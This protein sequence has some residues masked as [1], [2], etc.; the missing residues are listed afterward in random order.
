MDSAPTAGGPPASPG[1]LDGRAC[2]SLL[3]AADAG[4]LHTAWRKI[5]SYG[6]API[7][8]TTVAGLRAKWSPPSID[9]PHPSRPTL[10]GHAVMDL[11]APIP[12]QKALR[13]L[14]RQT[15]PDCLGWTT[16]TVQQL[17]VQP[18]LRILPAFLCGLYLCRAGGE[19]FEDA[20]N[21]S[22]LLPLW[23][24]PQGQGLRPIAIPTVWRKLAAQLLLQRWGPALRAAAGP[25]QFSAGTPD[26]ANRFASATRAAMDA[27]NC[28]HALLRTDVSNAFGSVHRSSLFEVLHSIDPTLVASY[29][30]WLARPTLGV[31][32][33]PN[34]QPV[35]LPASRG[36]PQGD[37]LSSISFCLLLA[38][39]LAEFGARPSGSCLALAFADDVILKTP[40]AEAG[41]ALQQWTDLLM[42]RGLG[43]NQSKTVVWSPSTTLPPSLAVRLGTP[44]PQPGGI[45]ICGLPLP[46][47]SSAPSEDTEPHDLPLGDD[48]FI[49]AFLARKTNALRRKLSTLLHV[50]HTLGDNSAALQVTTHILRVGLQGSYVHLFRFLPPRISLPWAQELDQLVIDHL[51]QA[52]QL[53]LTDPLPALLL[54]TPFSKGGLQFLRL[55]SEAALHFLAGASALNVAPLPGLRL[56]LPATDLDMA[57][58]FLQTRLAIDV[59]DTLNEFAPRP[60]IK[61][62]RQALSERLGAQTRTQAPWLVPPGWTSD[63]PPDPWR[64]HHLFVTSWVV[65]R[66]HLLLYGGP[67]RHAVAVHCGL[68]LFQPGQRC[69]YTPASTGRP[70]GTFL[71]LFSHH[72]MSCAH[73][74]RMHRHN[75]IRDQ[76]AVLLR[77]AQWHTRLEQLIDTPDGPKRCDIA[78]TGPAGEELVLDVMITAAPDPARP[79]S[80][81]LL[82][83]AQAKASRYAVQPGCALPR[84]GTFYPL[85]MSAGV[86][87]LENSAM[88][89]FHRLCA[90]AG[91]RTDPGAPAFW[92][93]SLHAW[94]LTAAAT[95]TTAALRASYRMHAPCGAPLPCELSLGGRV[96][97]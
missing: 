2:R 96:E 4:R 67:F 91:R 32:Y 84:G 56:E 43:V 58:A 88:R 39:P 28:S 20:C 95:F 51:C 37:P 38:R 44:A 85:L 9:P 49:R 19:V 74:P 46:L 82:Q 14:K 50:I 73:A 24:D 79:V 26:G 52:F 57:R 92:H 93:P 5:Q 90:T 10:D 62:L 64:L 22:R 17:A 36:I 45:T 71:G 86:P 15:A 6:L 8:D 33:R 21:A 76:W 78:A 87:F 27:T 83:A 40:L 54:R 80:S 77:Q 65:P 89:L 97:G 68:A 29:S 48:A 31:T 23:K 75:T 1:V 16:E 70:C 42:P 66:P 12:M 41:A 72:V 13:Q 53:P 25:Y 63:P 55:D 3:L 81:H 60:A 18:E 94:R 7:N 59:A 35:F 61:R 30:P 34:G 11:T 69:H 47:Q